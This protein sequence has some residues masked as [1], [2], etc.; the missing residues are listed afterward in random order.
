[1]SL[2][3]ERTTTPRRKVPRRVVSTMTSRRWSMG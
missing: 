1:V 2:K 3:V